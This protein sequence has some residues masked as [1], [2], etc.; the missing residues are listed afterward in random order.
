MSSRLVAA[1]LAATAAAGVV[2][3]ALMETGL[4]APATQ[5]VFIVFA[6]PLPALGWLLASRR[7]ELRYGWLLL[8]CGLFL[9]LSVLGVGVRA[10]GG[11][12]LLGSFLISLSP[13]FYG[14]TWIFVPLLF[15]DGRLPSRRWR[16]VAR[17]SAVAIAVHAVGSTGFLMFGPNMSD[18]SPLALIA[19][20]MSGVGQFVTWILAVV[21]F[22]GLVV[23]WR[24]SRMVERRQY[25]W[26]VGGM[27]VTMGGAALMLF[28][29]FGRTQIGPVV[30]LGVVTAMGAL[31]AA[32]VVAVVRHRLLDIRI[33]IKGS[34]LHLMF[35]LRPTVDEVL[36][37]LGTALEDAPEPVEQL[38]RLA[39]AVRTG[40]EVR[41]A[42]VTLAD[43]TRVV[44]GK[45]EGE[46]LVTMPVRGGLGRIECG[47]RDAGPL[48]RVDRRLLQALAVPAGLAIQSAG[49]V[50][51]LVNAQEAERRRIERNIHD[52]VQQQL[53]ALIA[54]LEL[55]RATGAG[56]DMLTQLREQARQTLTDLRE[57]AAGIHP[58]ALSQGG[59]VEAVEERCSRLPVHTRVSASPGL[60]ARRF[61]DEIE[62]AMYFTVSEAVAN[63]LKH[64]EAATIEVRLSQ[65][66]GRLRATVAD[67]GK[68]FTPGAAARR[69]LATLADRLDA[70]GGGL[71]VDSAPGEGTRVNA[72][73][74]ADE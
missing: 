61:A 60:R 29:I 39:T 11:P 16:P 56:P 14:L 51:R 4:P 3:G 53:V 48:T 21:V 54:G 50:T 38:G 49:L 40:L 64:A 59:L 27:V 24:R 72:W 35:D 47:P 70:L 31:P 26:M 63:A 66:D 6:L 10:Q 73:V 71:T 7:P 55:A 2:A 28:T 32:L 42:A 12:E 23:R 52:G 22:C 5:W 43:G 20:L 62:G 45:E 34:R 13:L 74:P 8:A 19:A 57:L 41:W 17:I 37:D 15:P 36:S 44:S 18:P 65:S 33:G 30:L 46:A 1:L 58:S 68:G 9:G 25:A 67:D 69:G